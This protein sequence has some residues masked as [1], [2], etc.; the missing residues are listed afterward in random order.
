MRN[1]T[2]WLKNRYGKQRE[3]IRYKPAERYTEWVK[4]PKH[5]AAPTIADM[6]FIEKKHIPTGVCVKLSE[7]IS[8]VYHPTFVWYHDGVNSL[9]FVSILFPDG[10]EWT[11]Y[12]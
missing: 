5:I 8:L 11:P 6:R 1:I 9:T 3:L 7:T 12:L 4:W 2:R 10:T